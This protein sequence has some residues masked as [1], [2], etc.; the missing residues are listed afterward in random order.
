V[1]TKRDWS[2]DG[3]VL[4]GLGREIEHDGKK[5]RP[6]DAPSVSMSRETPPIHQ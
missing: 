4:G 3:L 2:L 1:R 6:L 5:E